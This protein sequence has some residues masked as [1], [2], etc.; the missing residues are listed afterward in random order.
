MAKFAARCRKSR[1]TSFLFIFPGDEAVLG[2]TEVAV[3]IDDEGGGVEMLTEEDK[4]FGVDVLLGG[5][6]T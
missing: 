4:L 2:V 1:R 5:G 3:L 6:G